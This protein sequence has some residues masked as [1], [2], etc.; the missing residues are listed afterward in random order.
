MS[1]AFVHVT[2]V[3]KHSALKLSTLGFMM[4]IAAECPQR[5]VR[6]TGTALQLLRTTTLTYSDIADHSFVLFRNKETLL[7]YL[8]KFINSWLR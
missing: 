5:L 8:S 2:K 4:R 1:F 3:L 6:V 7:H